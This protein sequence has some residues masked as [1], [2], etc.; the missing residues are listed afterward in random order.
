VA[1]F[2]TLQELY[3]ILGRDNHYYK[4][5]EKSNFG[6]LLH[7]TMHL[8]ATD[9]RDKIYG[10]LALGRGIDIR[11][12]YSKTVR[13]VYTDLVISILPHDS[14]LLEYSGISFVK[15]ING[16]ATTPSWVPDWD[17]ITRHFTTSALLPIRQISP[18]NTV[19]TT[20][21]LKK[22]EFEHLQD[23]HIRG[24]I[25]QEIIRLTPAQKWLN[26]QNFSATIHDIYGSFYPQPSKDCAPQKPFPKLVAL[27]FTLMKMPKNSV[28][29]RHYAN[30]AA[31]FCVNTFL[32]INNVF[33]VT[34]YTPELSLSDLLQIFAEEFD[35]WHELV[36]LPEMYEHAYLA[37]ETEGLQERAFS[38]CPSGHFGIGPSGA[39][40]GDFLCK[41][42]GFTY[43]FILRKVDSHY[44]LVGSCW[45][46]GFF[47]DQELDE[48]Q[49][50]M[51]EIW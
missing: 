46:L 25:W 38:Q 48:D 40:D 35:S 36:D 8:Q 41:L 31:G 11:P 6:S 23:M 1:V 22:I 9:P 12:D 19:S 7:Y 14:T 4:T 16:P 21:S 37:K 17:Y 15:N 39:R 34:E 49:S 28:L 13:Q 43:P 50:V 32:R 47:S 2:S 30:L 45:V 24:Q 10:I 3:I 44:V 29:D 20:S 27:F 26:S 42:Y 51:L 33:N 5:F 18:V